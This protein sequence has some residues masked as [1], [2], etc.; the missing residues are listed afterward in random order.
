MQEFR[1]EGRTA[2]V[3]GAGGNPSLG[4]AHA[5]LLASRGA[6]VVVNDIGRPDAPG[7]SEPASAETV[8]GEIH[9]LGGHAVADIHSV[10]TE[11][12]AR[13][14][15][16]T[17]L[18]AFGRVDILV[19]N[20][21][22]SI[23]APFER[24]TAE[25]TRRHI[26][27]NLM[28]S[29]WMC[30]A[31]W[32]QMQQQG[33]GRIVNTGSGA[34]AGMWALV[35]YAASKGGIFSLTRGLAVEGAGFGIKANTLLPGGY[36]RMLFAQQEPNSPMYEHAKKN[37]PAESVSPLV[38]FLSHEQCPVSGECFDAMGGMARRV[39]LAHTE[40]IT[41]P[42]LTIEAVAD[43]WHDIMGQPGDPTVDLGTVD[44]SEWHL[45]PYAPDPA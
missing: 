24:M 29:L 2:I 18:E 35:A 28:G 9:A 33:Y 3:T 16:Q 31:A 12:G 1:F 20:A 13:A 42:N 8:A 21:G 36:T 32:P 7:Y 44:S 40:G 27:V 30:R 15:V 6:N 22:I 38:A 11:S 39:Y 45:K 41:D 4:R 43:G 25:D 26:D 19:N 14:V 17:A 5:L 10:A 23:A 37:L 34:F